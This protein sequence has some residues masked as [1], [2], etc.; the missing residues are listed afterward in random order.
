[1]LQ[2]VVSSAVKPSPPRRWF[3]SDEADLYVWPDRDGVWRGFEYCY[4]TG[5]EE[6]SLMWNERDGYSF[7]AIDDG[8]KT[9]LKND[10]PLAVA[11]G[12]PPWGMIARHFRRQGAGLEAG[13]YEFVLQR[14]VNA[15]HAGSG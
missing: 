2:E 3:H 1:M 10:A 13:L 11:D 7:A 9:P 6:Y 12:R 15:A 4:R 8:E 14:L 5:G